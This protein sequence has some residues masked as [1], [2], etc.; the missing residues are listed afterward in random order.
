[1]KMTRQVAMPLRMSGST[2]HV[3][4]TKFKYTKVF[5]DRHFGRLYSTYENF[6]L[7]SV[8]GIVCSCSS[9]KSR[10]EIVI[11]QTTVSEQF[12]GDGINTQ[13]ALHPER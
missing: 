8:Y 6:L 5:S 1:M 13:D 12:Y 2:V 9:K 10:S 7:Y 4:H 3:M 11:D